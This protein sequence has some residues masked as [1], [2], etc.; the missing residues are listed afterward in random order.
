MVDFW[1]RWHISLSQFI[2]R[3]LYIPIQMAL[4]RRTDARWPLLCAVAATAVSFVL[5]GLWHGLSLPFLAWGA[6]HAAGLVVAHVYG[7][8]LQKTLGTKRLKL[9]RANPWIRGLATVVT[10]EFVAC[11]LLALV[12]LSGPS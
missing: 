8:V 3:N 6:S 10:F 9:Y 12:L 11:S 7:H 2:R 1:E 4:M 5:A